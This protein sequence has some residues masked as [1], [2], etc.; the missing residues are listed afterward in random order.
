MP[1][2]RAQRRRRPRALPTPRKVN[3]YVNRRLQLNRAAK[4]AALDEAM[5][6][7]LW[8]GGEIDEALR[9][10]SGRAA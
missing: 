10:H 6:A 4:A 5:E 9:S 1:P 8:E 2:Q 7:D 3:N